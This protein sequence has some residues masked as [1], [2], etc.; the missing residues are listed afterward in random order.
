MKVEFTIKANTDELDMLYQVASE[1]ET[2]INEEIKEWSNNMI[3]NYNSLLKEPITE[4]SGRIDWQNIP[5]AARQVIGKKITVIREFDL[6]YA[7]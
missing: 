4:I 2:M 1:F 3:T 6:V 7:A 5:N